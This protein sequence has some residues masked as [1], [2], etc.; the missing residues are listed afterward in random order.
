MFRALLI[1][2]Q[3][4]LHPTD[5]THRVTSLELLFDLVFVYAITNV[6]ALMEHHV[7]GRTTLEAVIVLAVI[8]FGWCSYTWLG[9]QAKADEGLVRVAMILALGGMFF[10]ALSIPNAFAA[11]GNAAAVLA[12]SYCV[13]RLVQNAV[14]LI[15]AAGDAQLRSVLI[16]MLGVIV[17]S[18]VLLLIGAF[19]DEHSRVWW[20]LASVAVDQAGVYLVRSTRWRL[21]SASH[22]AERFS[23][24]VLIAIG[25]SVVALG[26]ASEGPDLTLE[27]TIGLLSGLAVA[28]SLWWLYFD[29]VALVAERELHHAEGLR[30]IRMAR[31]SY[32]Y[33]HLPMVAGIVFTA[34]GLALLVDARDHVSAGRYALYGGIALY[35]AGHFGFRMRNIGSINRPRTILMVLL[36]VLIPIVSGL[37]ALAQ[38]AIP[39]I[40]LVALI[41]FEVNAFRDWRADLRHSEHG[42]SSELRSTPPA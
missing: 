26:A 6:T 13:V 36:L 37:P 24:I 19:V 1:S 41:I 39:A 14:Y 9:N 3:S 33:L 30:R 2:V 18:L 11:E 29:V 20:W 21:S 38:L 7:G 23:L 22:F 40:L 16:G 12:V 4:H 15:A 34:L 27:R 28:V 42:M 31:D 35:L 8:W 32:T 17:T 10:V 5:D 25:E